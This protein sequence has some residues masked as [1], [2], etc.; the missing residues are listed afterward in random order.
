[1]NKQPWRFLVV[2]DREALEKARTA[3]SAGN[4]WARVAPVLIA[5]VTDV[6][7]DC[8][9]SDRRDYAPFDLGLAVGNLLAQATSEGVI[10]HPIAGFDPEALKAAFGIPERF[11]VMAVIVVGLPGDDSGLNDKHREAERSPRDRKPI[12]DV[13]F[14]NVWQP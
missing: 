2:D 5:A 14:R 13:V 1:M 7:L 9:L 6:D 4:Y 11:V 12:S 8:R 3:L 10:A